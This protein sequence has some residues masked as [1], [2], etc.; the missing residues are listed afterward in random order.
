MGFG[1]SLAELMVCQVKD[2]IQIKAN[3]YFYS[4]I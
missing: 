4:N 1:Y 3:L 2:N